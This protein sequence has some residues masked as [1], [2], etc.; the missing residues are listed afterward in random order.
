MRVIWIHARL[1]Y[2]RLILLQKK[3]ILSQGVITMKQIQV[4]A[5]MVDIC[6]M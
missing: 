3:Q 5:T 4:S 2:M 1:I 6:Y